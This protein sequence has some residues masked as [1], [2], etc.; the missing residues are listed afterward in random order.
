M[1]SNHIASSPVS[2]PGSVVIHN[3]STLLVRRS[4]IVDVWSESHLDHRR[5]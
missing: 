5:L 3:T 2:S 4:N 1:G